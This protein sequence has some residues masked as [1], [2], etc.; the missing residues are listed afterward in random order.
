LPYGVSLTDNGDGTATITGTPAAGSGGTYT[1]TVS[2]ANSSGTTATQSFTL[3]VNEAPSIS[4]IAD[5][6][7]TVG[8]NGSINV[9]TA[10]FPTDTIT[11]SGLPTGVT[12]TDNGNGTATIA[13]TPEAGSGGT[14][15][16]TVNA[17]NTS[18]PTATQTFVLTVDEAPSITSNDAAGFTAGTAGSFTVTTAGFPTAAISISPSD[19]LPP[20]VTLVDNGNGT[21]TLSSTTSA[22]AGIYNFTIDATNGTSPD[23]SQPFTLTIA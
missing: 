12:L 3:T 7:F 2:A 9:Q 23:A 18:G 10:G 17:A 14:Y 11:A 22:S 5:T 15:N 8:T 6:T 13:G 4:A 1:V 19:T 20:G 21:A 16:V